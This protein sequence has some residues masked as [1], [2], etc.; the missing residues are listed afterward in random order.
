M[1]EVVIFIKGIQDPSFYI[2]FMQHMTLNRG[3][4]IPAC[5]PGPG[6]LPEKRKECFDLFV[7]HN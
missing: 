3:E 1:L 5:L 2:Y 4:T 7:R 6:A